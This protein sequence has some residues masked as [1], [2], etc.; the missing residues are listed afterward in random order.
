MA[1]LLSAICIAN[2]NAGI[3][4]DIADDGNDLVVNVSGS[5]NYGTFNSF[6]TPNGSPGLV[7]AESLTVYQYFVSSNDFWQIP[8]ANG[9][10]D[11]SNWSSL[12]FN[13]G[14]QGLPLSSVTGESFGGWRIDTSGLYI[15]ENYISGA[16]W[17]SSARAVGPIQVKPASGSYATFTLNETGDTVT[18]RYNSSFTP[19]ATVPE[20][21]TAIAMGLLGIVGFAGNRRRRRQVSVA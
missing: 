5:F 11:D 16:Q 8:I 20:P 3:I 7:G 2:A 19:D 18:M 1:I 9:V 15:P 10:I 4:I 13:N 17:V 6:T 21:S 12:F 14:S